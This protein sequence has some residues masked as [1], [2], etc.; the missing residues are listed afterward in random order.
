MIMDWYKNLYEVAG[1]PYPRLSIAVAA[2][3]G[4]IVFGGGWW[5][6]GRQYAKDGAVPRVEANAG[7]PGQRTMTSVPT[8]H[9]EQTNAVNSP[10]VIGNNNQVTVGGGPPPEQSFCP[11]RGLVQS[12]DWNHE[13]LGCTDITI[14]WDAP[15]WERVEAAANLT[16]L[17]LAPPNTS[18]IAH[19]RIIDMTSRSTVAGQAIPELRSSPNH[20]EYQGI[21]LMVPRAQGTHSYRLEF[22]SEEQAAVRV[23]GPVVFTV[24][25]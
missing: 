14:P 2:V 17:V 6:I 20:V 21:T 19:I 10:N 1:A 9:I 25:P 13:K 12:A 23:T 24:K 3:V 4:A 18:A 11:D 7:A 5:L 16:V 22:R 8:I 15:G